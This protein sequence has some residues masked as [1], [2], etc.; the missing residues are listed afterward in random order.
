MKLPKKLTTSKSVSG[1]GLHILHFDHV[2]LN[3]PESRTFLIWLDTGEKN[4]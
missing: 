3:C 1:S 2:F 4:A